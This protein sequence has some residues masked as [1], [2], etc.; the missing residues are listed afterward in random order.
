[1]K[2]LEWGLGFR[3]QGSGCTVQGLGLVWVRAVRAV[4]SYAATMQLGNPKPLE[5]PVT[6]SAQV[7][8]SRCTRWRWFRV[9]VFP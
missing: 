2:S 3:V 9:Q 6:V 5:S 1:M 7:S 8:G 4:V